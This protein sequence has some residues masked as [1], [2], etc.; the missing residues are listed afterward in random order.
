MTTK[1]VTRGFSADQAL[2]ADSYFSLSCLINNG[3]SIE[4]LLNT[5]VAEGDKA[6]LL[7]IDISG[8]VQI[9]C[10]YACDISVLLFCGA[11]SPTFGEDHTQTGY[12]DFQEVY[13]VFVPDEF[14][15]QTV[16]RRP[17]SSFDQ[18]EG[19]GRLYSFKGHMEI[20][21]KWRE[22]GI[23]ESDEADNSPRRR[24]WLA[25]FFACSRKPG[26]ISLY[27][28]GSFSLRY[29]EREYDTSLARLLEGGE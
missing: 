23:L 26:A 17:A 20:P 7:S 10:T 27:W 11:T 19:T 24:T 2:N 29:N 1:T 15:V 22:L 4:E 12:T 9:A 16:T 21:E 3:Q 18:I 14:S 5:Y 25:G 13:R 28:T 8:H 6:S